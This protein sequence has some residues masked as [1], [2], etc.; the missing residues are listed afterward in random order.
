[1]RCLLVL[2]LGLLTVLDGQQDDLLDE[3][4]ALGVEGVAAA[5][6]CC[7]DRGEE[8]EGEGEEADCCEVD[9][10][11]CCLTSLAAL[12]PVAQQLEGLGGDLDARAALQPSLAL[13]PR[14]T[15]PPPTPPP[16]G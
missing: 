11:R 12:E 13:L 16:I 1:M 4:L 15:G 3:L 7:P 9:L 14:G 8:H 10:G 5:D 6:D 2:L